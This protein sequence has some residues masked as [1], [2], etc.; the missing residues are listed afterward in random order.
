[1]T[2]EELNLKNVL[3]FFRTGRFCANYLLAFVRDLFTTTE[4]TF[5]QDFTEI[6]RLQGVND[7]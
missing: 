4:E 1:M 2:S 5:L 3:T 6:I 7:S